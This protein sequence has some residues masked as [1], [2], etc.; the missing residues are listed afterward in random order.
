VAG[1][2]EHALVPLCTLDRVA[3][4]LLWALAA[5]M[6]PWLVRAASR[7][8]RITAAMSWAGALIV[9]SIVLAQQIGALAPP[10]PLAAGVTAAV[11]ATTF[12][13]RRL[14]APASATVA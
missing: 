6:L 2:I 7:A 5:L 1:A 14:R 12:G 11:V 4:A 10:L 13:S 3:P 9:A 8:L